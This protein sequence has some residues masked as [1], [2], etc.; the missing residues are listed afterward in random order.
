MTD[1]SIIIWDD[2]T[3]CDDREWSVTED[4]NSTGDDEN[5]GCDVLRTSMLEDINDP[6]QDETSAEGEADNDDT[7]TSAVMETKFTLAEYWLMLDEAGGM[8][9]DI[10]N[11]ERLSVPATVLSKHF[12]LACDIKSLLQKEPVLDFICDKSNYNFTCLYT[13]HIYCVL[14]LRTHCLV[15]YSQM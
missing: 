5:S 2:D 8:D 3:C 13:Y 12:M 14:C 4:S 15:R 6:T 11:I 9:D 7:D 10:S 1:D